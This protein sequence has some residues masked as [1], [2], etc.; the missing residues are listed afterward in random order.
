GTTDGANPSA[1][2]IADSQGD[3][4]GTTISGGASGNG[5]VFELTPN[6]SGY[7]ESVIHSFAGG[8]T[9][10]ATPYA[11]LLLDSQGNLY[12]TARSGGNARGD[13]IV[14]E[15]KPGGG[16]Y[17]ESVLGTFGGN[18]GDIGGANPGAGLIADAEG[19]LFGTAADPGSSG[20]GTVFELRP[21]G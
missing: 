21:D 16:G 13:G 10:G 3:L 9:D 17:T 11:R 19:D 4:F 2:L 5:V 7:T 8:P 14:F 6:G 20:N 1:A 15:L 18:I 12:G